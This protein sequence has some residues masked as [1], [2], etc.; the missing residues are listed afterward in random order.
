MVTFPQDYPAGRVF[1]GNAFFGRSQE[2]R[3][4]VDFFFKNKQEGIASKPHNHRTINLD[5]SGAID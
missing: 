3:H 1:Y 2:K 4:Q 5:I